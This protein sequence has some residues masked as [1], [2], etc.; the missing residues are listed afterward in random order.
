MTDVRCPVCHGL[1]WV[2]EKHPDKAW[3]EE[4]GGCQCSARVPCTCNRPNGE[5]MPDVQGIIEEI[6][7]EPKTTRH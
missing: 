7:G 3:S 5:D 1:G 6:E 2:C 4:P